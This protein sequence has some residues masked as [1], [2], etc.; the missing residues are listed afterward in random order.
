MSDRI[1]L[2]KVTVETMKQ[3]TRPVLDFTNMS[4]NSEQLKQY[5]SEI[6]EDNPEIVGYMS[7]ATRMMEMVQHLKMDTSWFSLVSMIIM[8]KILE[9]QYAKQKAEEN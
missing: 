6:E 7:R 5:I 4:I 3:V 2:P 1:T 9:T 8:Y